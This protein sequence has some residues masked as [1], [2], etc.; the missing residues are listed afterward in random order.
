MAPRRKQ[1]EKLSIECITEVMKRSLPL[2]DANVWDHVESDG[3]DAAVQRRVSFVKEMLELNPTGV[4]NKVGLRA[5]MTSF[6][7][8][9]Q[10][11]FSP[12]VITNHM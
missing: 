3:V 6:F 10:T 11:I 1:P 12:H 8:F 2:A 4:F 9:H 5:S 7:A